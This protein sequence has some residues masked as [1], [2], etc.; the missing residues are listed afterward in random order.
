MR[1]ILERFI[2]ERRPRSAVVSIFYFQNNP[3]LCFNY[4]KEEE[5]RQQRGPLFGLPL[6]GAD[7]FQPL[8]RNV[9]F[10]NSG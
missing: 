7:L 8:T 1:S 10:R 2:Y 4:H 6:S 9:V 5:S 3:E